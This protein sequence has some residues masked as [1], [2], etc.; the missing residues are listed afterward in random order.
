MDSV[1]QAT[2]ERPTEVT[3]CTSDGKCIG[4]GSCCTNFLPMSDRE[5]LIVKR[6]VKAHAIQEQK[7]GA[8][9]FVSLI[10]CICPFLD[11]G[12]KDKKKCAIY[13]VRPE[14][15]RVFN[16]SDYVQGRI[17]FSASLAEAVVRDVRAT[18]F[19]E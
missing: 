1:F 9:P 19:R 7:H 13:P 12:R 2:M 5:V 3:D 15:C 14:I 18:F 6:Y 10:D 17:P 11:I 4:C 16:C 8:A